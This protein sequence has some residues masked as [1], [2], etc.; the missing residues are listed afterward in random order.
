MVCT[1]FNVIAN[2]GGFTSSPSLQSLTG[3]QICFELEYYYIQTCNLIVGHLHDCH[4]AQHDET[5]PQGRTE[6]SAE[7]WNDIT[8]VKREGGRVVVMRVVWSS[9]SLVLIGYRFISRPLTIVPSP[10]I[11]F[12]LL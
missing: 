12:P 10:L 11:N 5:V 8:L 1:L 7:V 9:M 6:S 4:V 3:D 2:E